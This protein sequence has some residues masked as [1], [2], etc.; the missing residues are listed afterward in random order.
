M[1]QSDRVGS[2]E[3]WTFAA[4][5]DA[6]QTGAAHRECDVMQDDLHTSAQRE[7]S[8][9]SDAAIGFTRDDCIS[10]GEVG[11]PKYCRIARSDGARPSHM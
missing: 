1:I 7:L 2:F 8:M 10:A 9:H 6:S 3:S 5:H 4:P 11:E